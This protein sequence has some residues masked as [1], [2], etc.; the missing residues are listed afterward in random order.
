MTSRFACRPPCRIAPGSLLFLRAAGAGRRRRMLSLAPGLLHGTPALHDLDWGRTTR[1]VVLLFCNSRHR[2]ERCFKTRITPSPEEPQ[3][4]KDSRSGTG[5]E[6]APD[7]RNWWL[8]HAAKRMKC[9]ML[10]R[11]YTVTSRL[12]T[13]IRRDQALFV[14]SIPSENRS[15]RYLSSNGFCRHCPFIGRK[16]RLKNPLQRTIPDSKAKRQTAPGVA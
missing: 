11:E 6:T 10:W 9:R 8:R 12:K 13:G 7:E 14:V 5:F 15:C 1:R 16:I 3:S 4:M 2:L